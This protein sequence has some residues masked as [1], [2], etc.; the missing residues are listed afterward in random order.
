MRKAASNNAIAGKAHS[1]RKFSP[2]IEG[3]AEAQRAAD[4]RAALLRGGI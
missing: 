4:K 2:P 3:R 1:T